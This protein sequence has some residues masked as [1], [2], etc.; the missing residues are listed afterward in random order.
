MGPTYIVRDGR[1]LYGGRTLIQWLPEIVD[2]IVA[3]ARPRRV[4][5]F[6]SVTRGEDGPNSDIDLIVVLAHLDYP[7]RHEVEANLYT[8]V[9]GRPP[10][11]IFVTDERE[12]ARRRDVIGSMHYWPLREG[13]TVYEGA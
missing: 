8:L 7:K 6:G 2:A 11:H 13:R 3:A 12:C 9:P 4:I 1:A 10:L 5:L